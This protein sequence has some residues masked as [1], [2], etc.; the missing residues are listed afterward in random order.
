VGNQQEAA[1]GRA[2]D[3]LARLRVLYA[4]AVTAGV[5]GGLEAPD[6]IVAR[7]PVLQA[8]PAAAPPAGTADAA[9]ELAAA[10]GDIFTGQYE[11]VREELQEATVA[12]LAA[13]D[14]AAAWHEENE[15]RKHNFVPLIMETM[16]Q[17]AARGK[18]QGMY[19]GGKKKAEEARE[20]ARRERAAAAKAGAL[21]AAGGGA[22]SASGSSGGGVV[23][24]Q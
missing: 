1:E 4:A 23:G 3:A 11:S 17:L 18:L 24:R 2:A 10:G 16:K 5:A 19:E 12:V 22:A 7:T 21:G 8:L 6:A 9:G 15:R 20:R 13:R 14:K